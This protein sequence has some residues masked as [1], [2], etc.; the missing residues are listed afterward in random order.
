MNL[1][2]VKKIMRKKLVL[3]KEFNYINI[4]LPDHNSKDWHQN[5]KFQM[6]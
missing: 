6:L 5:L 3:N 4:S 1:I 2:F